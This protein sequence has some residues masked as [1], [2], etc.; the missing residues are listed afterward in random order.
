MKT[1]TKVASAGLVFVSTTTFGFYKYMQHSVAQSDY[2]ALAVQTARSHQPCM[3]ALGNQL[4][5]GNV[6]LFDGFTRV[7][8]TEVKVGHE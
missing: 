2:Y 3:T 1:L 6:D 8:P 5:P 4:C 7:H